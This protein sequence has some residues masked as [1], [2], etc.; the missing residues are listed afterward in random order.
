MTKKTWRVEEDG[1]RLAG[2]VKHHLDIPHRR[3]QDLIQRGAVSVDGVVI[4]EIGRQLSVACEIEVRTDAPRKQKVSDS[5]PAEILH[6]DK[7]LI[8]VAKPAGILTVPREEDREIPARHR[9]RNLE[10]W[11]RARDIARGKRPSVL[12]VQ[13]LD[14]GTSGVLVFPRTR[15]AYEALKPAFARHD[16][17]RSYRAIVVGA[18]REEKGEL[19]HRLIE[20]RGRVIIA[21]PTEPGAKEAISHYTVLEHSGGH[22]LLELKLQT[23]RRNQIRVGC[24]REKFPLLGDGTY[25]ERS[26]QIGRPAL[27]AN[28][29]TLID[30][31]TET[32][33]TFV[34]PEPTD[35]RSAWKALGGQFLD[36]ALPSD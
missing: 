7:H 27:H 4:T 33:L 32:P 17:D 23:G 19:R 25:G 5:P 2:E 1:A 6:E 29:L 26:K 31:L 36:R 14:K 30:P 18:P 28:R 22:T 8:V 9:E 24:A 13:R 35:F 11:L 15:F 10:D 3:A 12:I 21:H 20:K 34:M 16:I